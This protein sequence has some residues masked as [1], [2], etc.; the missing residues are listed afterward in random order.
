MLKKIVIGVLVAL[1]VFV[2]LGFAMGSDFRVERRAT[3]KADVARVHE[4]CGELKN[5]PAWS[6]WQEQ[7]PTIVTT[8][9][10]KTTGVGAHQSWTG[11]DGAGELT[12]TRCDPQTGITYDMAFIDG[13]RRSPSVAL[14]NYKPVDGGVEVAWIIE[15]EL[16]IP[17]IGPYMALVFDKLVGPSFE[18][19]LDKLKMVCEKS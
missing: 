18:R 9:G 5:W 16:N 14:M 3:I 1:A 7:D 6:P 13:D 2:A 19:G 8:F 12:F 4:Y 10:E 17:V 11:K 15:G